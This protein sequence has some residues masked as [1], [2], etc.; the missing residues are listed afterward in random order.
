MRSRHSRANSTSGT[1][2]KRLN[3]TAVAWIKNIALS[4]NHRQRCPLRY[5]LRA[6]SASIPCAQLG[7][8]REQRQGGNWKSGLRAQK[9]HRVS[10][11]VHRTLKARIDQNDISHCL[12]PEQAPPSSTAWLI[13]K[14]NEINQTIDHRR[15]TAAVNARMGSDGRNLSSG[16]APCPPVEPMASMTLRPRCVMEVVERRAP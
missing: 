5:R 6:G 10:E 8:C 4:F 16:F 13:P 1:R 12:V 9:G 14:K 2:R 15:R 7:E 11:T 3:K